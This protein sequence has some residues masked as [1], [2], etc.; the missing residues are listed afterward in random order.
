MRAKAD[1]LIIICLLF[2]IGIAEAVG[3]PDTVTVTTDKPWV[4]ANNVDQSTI[5]VTVTNTTIPN[6]GPVSGVPIILTINDS[7]YGTLSAATVTTDVSGTAFSTFKV[8]T[9]SGAAQIT[10]TIN[11]LSLS[12][13][14]IQNIDHDS[15]YIVKFD[16]PYYGPVAKEAPFNLSMTDR[17][18]NRIDNRNPSE[19]HTVSLHV[20]GPAPDDCGF[21]VSPVYKHD[22]AAALDT[23]G[24]LSIKIK[25]TSKIG[26][27][28]ILLDY[29]GSIPE[30]IETI[31]AIATDVPYSMTGSI[32]HGGSVPANGIAYFTLDYFLFDKYGN[33]LGNRTIWVNTTLSNEQQI[34]TSNALGQIRINYGPK[35]A[36]WNNIPITAISIDNHTVTNTLFASFVN[37]DPVNM[38]FT[39]VPQNMASLE[40]DPSAK[41]YVLAKVVDAYGNPVPGE[42]VTFNITPFTPNPAYNKTAFPRLSST[43]AVT[44]SEGDAR[45]L[46]YPGTFAKRSEIGYSKSASQSATIV[47]NWST[48]FRPAIVTWK[49]YPYMSVNATAVPQNVHL[50]DTIDI[51]IAVTGDGYKMGGNPVTAILDMDCSASMKNPD[52]N[53]HDRLWNAKEAA[54]AFVGEMKSDRDFVG[55][56]S[57]GTDN[58]NQFHLA[59][60]PNMTYVQQQITSLLQGSQSKDLPDSINEALHNITDTQPGR[61]DDEV[62][63]VIVLNDGNS[64]I[65]NQGQLNSFV[66]YATGQYPPIYIYT[67]LYLDGA[68]NNDQKQNIVQMSELANRT[69]G[70]MFIP[71]TPEELK[72]VYIDIAHELQTL[73]GV[74][75]TMDLDFQNVEVNST[76]MDGGLVFDYVPVEMGETSPDSRTTILWPNNTR[77]F[78]NQSNEWTAA[79]NYQLHF[80]IG[81]INTS[82]TWQAT[83]RLKVNQ[84][85]LVKVFGN[86]SKINFNGA[87]GPDFLELPDLYITVT[88][89]MTIEGTYTGVLDVSNLAVTKSGNHTDFIPLQWNLHYAGKDKATE[90]WWYSYN[91]GPWIQFGAQ[92][93]LGPADYTHH[94]Q[95]DVKKFPPGGYQIRIF[96]VAP[97]AREDEEVASAITVGGPGI[98]IKLE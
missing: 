60:F 92:S 54:K 93:G 16:H 86:T 46:F 13:S 70:K 79:N 30:K 52:S 40:V 2:L 44:D 55:L 96:A 80:N 36:V 87:D 14:T 78:V 42:T 81:T 97:D 23:N 74:N 85:G 45:V 98:F 51:T 21:N 34:Y 22:I 67:I 27:N 64:N 39:I 68:P 53:G 38:V 65:K 59:P 82:D 75:A 12:G 62:R 61:P 90:T 8:K 24:N 10:A 28:N 19:T 9:K 35:T 72:Q 43:S 32:S 71:T 89:N 77:S 76:P 37:T 33:P 1:I 15:P 91:N 3:I 5:I 56:V 17:H 26:T 29:F 7:V 73:A 20:H 69:G 66:S 41:G 50:N 31:T 18:G 48:V 83:Y 4:V 88:P 57:F 95:L 49:N 63:A 6:Q 84:I 11:S 94:A 47:A 58:N 25:L